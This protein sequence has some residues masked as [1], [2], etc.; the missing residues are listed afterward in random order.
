RCADRVRVSGEARGPGPVRCLELVLRI[1]AARRQSIKEQTISAAE[2]QVIAQRV[3]KPYAWLELRGL[4]RQEGFVKTGKEDVIVMRDACE[5]GAR[6]AGI[7]LDLAA[8]GDRFFSN[9]VVLVGEIQLTTDSAVQGLRHVQIV[10]P[11]A[12]LERELGKNPPLILSVARPELEREIVF[13]IGGQLAGV[14]RWQAEQGGC[15][16]VACGRRAVLRRAQ[17]GRV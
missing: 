4:R 10:V 13:A 15:E 5:T 3:G 2:H 8:I 11:H 7:L 9:D 1:L 16:Y 14:A 12:K 17:R 6:D